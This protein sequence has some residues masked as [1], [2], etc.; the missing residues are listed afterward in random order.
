MYIDNKRESLYMI[1]YTIRETAQILGVNKQ[2]IEK[3]IKRHENDLITDTDIYFKANKWYLTNS[4]IEKIRTA[5]DAKTTY[6]IPTNEEKSIEASIE[7]T[8]RNKDKSTYT[9]ESGSVDLLTLYN[10]AKTALEARANDYFSLYTDA[11]A[12]RDAAKEEIETL[13]QTNTMLNIR[14]N[15]LKKELQRLTD[16]SNDLYNRLQDLQKDERLFTDAGGK[17]HAI[18]KSKNIIKPQLLPALPPPVSSEE[19]EIIIN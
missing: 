4:G 13:K 3:R 6:T 9:R 14:L 11:K 2:A 5:K 10:D 17:Y 7:E 18:R 12:E 1:G 15:D 16:Y 8:K 19:G